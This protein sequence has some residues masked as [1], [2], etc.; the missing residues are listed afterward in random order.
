VGRDIG[1]FGT[2][3]DRV[4]TDVLRGECEMTREKALEVARSLVAQRP[5][6]GGTDAIRPACSFGPD[7]VRLSQAARLELMRLV[8][9]AHLPGHFDT[10]LDLSLA[11]LSAVVGSSTA[12]ALLELFG[13]RAD[14][15]KLRRVEAMGDHSSEVIDFHLDSSLKTM[16]IPLNDESEYD[17]NRILYVT[18]EGFWQPRRRVGMAFLHDNSVPHG[19]TPLL[20]GVRYGLFFLTRP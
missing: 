16:H 10:K 17:G 20:K 14:Q 4:G 13:S 12:G 7:R 8:D 3:V 1:V 18:A 19:V 15:I 6:H 2:H 9:A 5:E 11:E